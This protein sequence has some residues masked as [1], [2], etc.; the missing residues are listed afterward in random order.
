MPTQSAA[1]RDRPEPPAPRSRGGRRDL[2]TAALAVVFFAAAAVEGR[3]IEDSAH[4]L[5][6]NWPPVFAYW[7]PHWGP[8]TPLAAA[9]AVAVV[10]YGPRAARRLGR[11]GLPWAVWG[12]SMA[13]TWSLALV[14]GWDRGVAGRLASRY[15]YLRSV[16]RFGDPGA[17]LR[18]FTHH[19]LL[20]TPDPWPAHVAGHPPAAVLT[21]VGLDR[22]GLGG[23]GWAAAFVITVGASAGAAVLV[24]LRALTSGR[25]ARTAAPFLVLA[26]AAVWAGVS[27]DGYYTAVGAWAVA[28][29]ALAATTGTGRRRAVAAL[30]SG[31]L[32]GLLCYLSYGLVLY[33]AMAAAVLLLTRTARPLPWFVAGAAVA[34]LCFTLAG[35]DW[36]EAYRLLVTRYNQGAGGER[37]Q[38]YFLWG[39][40]AAAVLLSGLPAVTGTARAVSSAPGA[41]RAWW[42]GAP[43]AR[44]RL[45]VLV[46]VGLAMILVA[47]A[48]GMSKAE[49]ERIWQPFTLWLLPAAALLPE[50][51]RRGW[52][53][54]GA[55]TALLV[56]HLLFTGW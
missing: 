20:H 38:S 36:W 7:D 3:G 10:R 30:G 28:L 11:R 45:V 54:T 42:R 46:L 22:I 35:F 16:D 26:P 55:L 39:N 6:L 34:P 8:G 5:H 29:L 31:L 27:A 15:E 33:A 47:D 2:V 4:T 40:L 13:W 52:L 24:T 17:A 18:D 41:V 56:N 23:G 43:D 51:G 14:D 53:A 32:F 25:L 44:G 1:A 37:P 12:A 48:S 50:R 9:V 49:T 21:F 19:I